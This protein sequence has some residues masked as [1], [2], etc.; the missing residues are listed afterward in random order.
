MGG[1]QAQQAGQ[2]V[3]ELLTQLRSEA[4]PAAAAAAEELVAC[5]VGLYGAGLTEIV[6]IVGDDAEAGRRL[7]ARLADDPLVESLLL[8]HDLH[9]V[10]ISVRVERGLDQVRRH[11]GSRTAEYQGVDAEGVV[12][13]RLGGSGHACASSAAAVSA[14]IERAV[15][16]AAPEAAA[17]QVE[18]VPAPSGELP[19][20]QITR[21]PAVAR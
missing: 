7:L 18:E 5:L 19:L 4:G 14:A 3:T 20:L 11:L 13:V 10:D 1:Q 21:R 17:V 9:P 8:V 2:R 15:T 16:E 6:R 12:H